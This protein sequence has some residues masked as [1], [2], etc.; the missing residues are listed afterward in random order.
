MA[1]LA[2]APKPAL[3]VLTELAELTDHALVTRVLNGDRSAFETL[4]RRHNRLLYRCIRSLVSDEAAVEEAMQQTYLMA[5]QRLSQFGGASAFSTWLVRIGLNEGLQHLRRT[6]KWGTVGDDLSEQNE[7]AGADEPSPEERSSARE[8][9]QLVEEVLERIP[10]GYRLALMLREVEGLSTAEAAKAMNVSE[11]TVKQR[12]FRGRQMMRAELEARTGE[13]I[14]EL[15]A[16]HAER[17][18]RVV[19]AVLAQLPPSSTD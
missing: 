10:P 5:F 12:V 18:N 2:L 16:F 13:A 6:R 14:N 7:S 9:V 4:M 8:T 17:C 15:F 19:S 11:D 1:T 3:L